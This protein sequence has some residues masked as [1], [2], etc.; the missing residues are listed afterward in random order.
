[1]NSFNAAG[2]EEQPWADNGQEQVEQGPWSDPWQNAEWDPWS[3]FAPG[4]DGYT[5]TFMSLTTARKTFKP[6]DAPTK[7]TTSVQNKFDG[8]DE[9]FVDDEVEGAEIADVLRKAEED[10]AVKTA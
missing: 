4:P 1:M 10:L 5:N 3:S 6:K 8:I 9:P 7:T 2:A